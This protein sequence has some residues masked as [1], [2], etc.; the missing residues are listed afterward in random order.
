[1]LLAGGAV[2]FGPVSAPN[3]L[4]TG[5]ITGNFLKNAGSS[6]KRFETVQSA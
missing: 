6:A 4:L 3:S 1:M 2:W 5:K